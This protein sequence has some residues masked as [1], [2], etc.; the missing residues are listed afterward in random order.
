MSFIDVSFSS[1]T[2]SPFY[3]PLK[4]HL[5]FLFFP[6]LEVGLREARPGEDGDAAALRHGE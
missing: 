6:Q 2:F 3:A 1:R 5:A 4:F